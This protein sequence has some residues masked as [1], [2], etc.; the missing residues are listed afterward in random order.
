MINESIPVGISLPREVIS[1]IDL[2]RKDISRSKY[3]LRLIQKAYGEKNQ[4]T[5][6]KNMQTDLRVAH[7]GQSGVVNTETALESSYD[8]R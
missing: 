5:M 3:M 1:R 8:H 2:D 7:S 6:K 4:F